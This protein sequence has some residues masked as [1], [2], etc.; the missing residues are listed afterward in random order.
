MIISS[1]ILQKVI[2][3]IKGDPGIRQ[4]DDDAIIINELCMKIQKEE[5]DKYSDIELQKMRLN[6]PKGAVV[7]LTL[8]IP[9]IKHP[10]EVSYLTLENDPLTGWSVA[11][12]VDFGGVGQNKLKKRH[13]IEATKPNHIVTSFAK[14]YKHYLG[15]RA[16]KPLT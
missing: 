14:I 15:K 7:Y 1:T 8:S 16:I 2:E 12:Y 4:R 13:D 10:K 5:D 6:G 3:E 9:H 11:Y